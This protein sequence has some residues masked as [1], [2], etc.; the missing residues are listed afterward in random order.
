MAPSDYTIAEQVVIGVDSLSYT[1]G[2]QGRVKKSID[3]LYDAVADEGAYNPARFVDRAR[4]AQAT[5]K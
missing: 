3:A 4:A 1:L 5:I 2:D